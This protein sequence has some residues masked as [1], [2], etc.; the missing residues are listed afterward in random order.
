MNKDFMWG[1][2][3]KLSHH[4]WDD[5]FTPPRGWYLPKMYTEENN[6]DVAVWD[7]TIGYIAEH[8]FNAVLID[9]G[10]GMQYERHPEISAPDAW[11]KDFH[12]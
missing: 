1:Y 10:D 5:E 8:G 2:M 11:S 3:L 7:E 6:T 12:Y 9:V 4:M